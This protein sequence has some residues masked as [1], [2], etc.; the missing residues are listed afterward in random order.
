MEKKEGSSLFQQFRVLGQITGSIPFHYQEH[1]IQSFLTTTIEKQWIVYECNKLTVRL[2]GPSNRY[3]ITAI[4][5]LPELVFAAVE[6]KIVVWNRLNNLGLLEVHDA[7]IILL[8]TLGKNYIISVDLEQKL[9]IW[10]VHYIKQTKR[11]SI[12]QKVLILNYC[13]P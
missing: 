13:S 11:A 4:C 8:Q 1:K 12:N 6:N 7:P 3:S 10:N 9:L 5:T 2:I